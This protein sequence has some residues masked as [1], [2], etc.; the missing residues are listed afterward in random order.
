[1]KDKCHHARVQRVSHCRNTGDKK[2]VGVWKLPEVLC[3]R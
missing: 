2:V 1:M 3:V